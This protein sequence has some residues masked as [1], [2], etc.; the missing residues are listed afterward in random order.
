VKDL[1]VEMVVR[2][3]MAQLFARLPFLTMGL[4]GAIASFFI[5]KAV[6][7]FV[8]KTALGLN[9]LYID[10]QGEAELRA[11]NEKLREIEE[12]LVQGGKSDLEIDKMVIDAARG[13][14]RIG[15]VCVYD[16]RFRGM[17]DAPKR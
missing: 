14:Y 17:Q 10:I 1:I 16:A 15:R 2:Q 3:A 4:P 5:E 6:V 13:F 12:A 7:F 11:Y 9:F 8:E